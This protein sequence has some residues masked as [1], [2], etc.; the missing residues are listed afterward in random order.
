MRLVSPAR[1]RALAA[2]GVRTVRDLLAHYPR[3]YIDLSAVETVATA[4]IGSSC[5]IEGV[6]HDVKLK[7]PRPKLSLVEIGLVDRTG[8][9][10]VTAFRQPWLADRL[11]AGMRV[12][13]AG[14]VEF[15]YGFKRMTN[16]FLEV[17]EEPLATGANGAGSAAGVA[18]GA[19]APAGAAAG[20][21]SSQGGGQTV[22][23]IIPVH[24]ATEKL[25]TAW[26]RRLVAN[27]LEH[28]RGMY[29]PLPVSLRE[30]RRLM[31]RHSAL[32][33]IHFP[34]TMDEMMQAKERLAYEE[35]LML[36]LFLM[37]EA[38][39][40]AC[41]RAAVRHVTNGGHVRALAAALPFRL[42]PEQEAA[43]DDMLGELAS[44]HIANHLILGDVGTGKTVVA[45][46]AL[47]A[48]ADT[49]G[50]AFLMAPTEVL[51]RQH[52]ESLGPLF[53]AAG[54]TC[55]LLTGSTSPSERAG[56]VQLFSSGDIDVLIGTH[57]LLEPDVAPDNLT[58]VV[59]DE[60]Q[61]FGVEQRA[62]LL[63]KGEAPDAVY[64]TATPIPR[65][66]ALA[67]FGDLT[68]SYIRHRPHDA[69]RRTTKV[70][71]K[72]QRGRAYDA[73]KAALARGEQVYVV[74]PLV[75]KGSDERNAKSAAYSRDGEDAEETL[76]PAVSIEGDAD[77][78]DD[79]V[80]A[81][82]QEAR[83]LQQSVFSDFTVALLHGKMPA[84]EKQQVMNRFRTGEVQVLV[85]TTVIEVGVDVP[86]ATV[87]IVEDADR[88]GLSQLHQLRGRVGRGEKSGEVYLVSASKTDA[89]LARLQAMESTDDGFELA[90]FDLSLRREGDILGNRQSG[91][92]VLRLVNVVRDKDIIEAAHADARAMLAQDPGLEAPEHRALA[93]EMRLLFKNERA[94]TGG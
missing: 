80:A 51:A 46:F 42:T 21:G 45:A 11:K 10:I 26:I 81:A 6:V 24:P 28:V 94:K 38:A 19:G 83:M 15:N 49:G 16:P 86:N 70:Y 17:V 23:K 76:H 34:R 39:A 31:S 14:K 79:D 60:Q 13:V 37:A 74:C 2:L 12:A 8:V 44:D 29:D 27:A 40:R 3:R 77:F 43:R 73:A 72:Q 55:A 85:A 89:A 87:M 9:L 71:A 30:H 7:R 69:A 1:E 58:L 82:T 65:S 84:A 48:A 88:F 53:E 91:A 90:A 66:L 25:S 47:A 64:L 67:L 36:E 93:R 33:C 18:G 22:G 35:L 4:R 5:T 54:V 41:G 92:S 59:I 78:G 50:Q 63:K 56:I 61:R 68:L 75:G 20:G 62:R 52:A 57:A 32:S